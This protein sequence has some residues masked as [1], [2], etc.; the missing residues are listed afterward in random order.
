MTATSINVSWRQVLQA[1]VIALMVVMPDKGRDVRFEITG[2]EVILQQ[3]A[4]L[5]RLVP[6]FH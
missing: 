2:Q 1:L 3:D 5:E 4:V 6:A